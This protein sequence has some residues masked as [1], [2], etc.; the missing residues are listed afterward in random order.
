MNET[1]YNTTLKTASCT[2][3]CSP[4]IIWCAERWWACR[5]GEN[6]P[7][8]ALCQALLCLLLPTFWTAGLAKETRVIIVT[9]KAITKEAR[10]KIIRG[11]SIFVLCNIYGDSHWKF[12]I[13]KNKKQKTITVIVTIATISNHTVNQCQAREIIVLSATPG[14]DATGAKRGKTCSRC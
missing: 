14:K 2:K 7:W 5:E 6:H 4:P 10:W 11:I 1:K 12:L 13:A 8:D 9:V 3:I